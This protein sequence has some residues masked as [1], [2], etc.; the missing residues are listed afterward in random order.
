MSLNLFDCFT[1]T[2]VLGSTTIINLT[3]ISW[4]HEHKLEITKWSCQ[5]SRSV[6]SS[7]NPNGFE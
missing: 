1:D 6:V 7:Q 5:N 4:R 3:S 2:Y